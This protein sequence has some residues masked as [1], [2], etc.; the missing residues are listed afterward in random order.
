MLNLKP[1]KSIKQLIFNL[2][3]VE[4]RDVI[5]FL[6]FRYLLGFVMKGFFAHSVKLSEFTK[7]SKVYLKESVKYR[8]SLKLQPVIIRN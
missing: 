8:A 1:I 2:I 4:K 6:T 7:L 3:E 5:Q